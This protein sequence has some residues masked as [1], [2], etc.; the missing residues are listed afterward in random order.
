VIRETRVVEIW[1]ELGAEVNLVGSLRTGLLIAHRDI[2]FHL[3]TDPFDLEIGFRAMGRLARD[4]R[5]VKIRY[6]NVLEAEGCVEWHAWFQSAPEER[7]Q[8]DII[9]LRRDSI[10]AGHMEQVAERIMAT[11]TD[12]TRDAILTIKRDLPPQPKIMGIE[13]YA[14][15][16][17]DGVRTLAE[18]V[19]WKERQG[20]AAVLDWMP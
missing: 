20:E 1:R 7:W 14:A 11:L 19:A 4:P 15:V 10:Y 16:M 18:M 8:I 17:R 3:Y 12:E 2:D 9:H 6:G 13:V 5:I